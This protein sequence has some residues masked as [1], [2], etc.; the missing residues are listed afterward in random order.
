MIVAGEAYRSA[1]AADSGAERRRRVRPR[2]ATRVRD[3]L[4]RAVR[5]PS[6]GDYPAAM[7]SRLMLALLLD[8]AGDESAPGLAGARARLSTL[9]SLLRGRFEPGRFAL[10][11]DLQPAFPAEAFWYLYGRPMAAS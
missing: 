10:D 11:D 5:E 2:A 1:I 4:A 8:D 3:M 7:Q 9:D 6:Q